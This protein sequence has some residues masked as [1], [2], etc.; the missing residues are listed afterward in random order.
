MDVFVIVLSAHP[1]EWWAYYALMSTVGEVAGGYLTYRVAEKGGR[2][3]SNGIGRPNNVKHWT[4]A[5]PGKT[6]G[7]GPTTTA[8]ELFA[9]M[10][11]ASGVTIGTCFSICPSAFPAHSYNL[12]RP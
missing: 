8:P 3:I 5:T 1:Y 7:S 2:S 11:V 6:M 4:K 12:E 9:A 10:D